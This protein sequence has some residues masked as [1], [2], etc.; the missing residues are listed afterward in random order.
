M[1]NDHERSSDFAGIRFCRAL[2]PLF[3]CL[4]T[5]V[6]CFGAVSAQTAAR[7]LSTAHFAN[8]FTET[9]SV[10]IQIAAGEA[11][12]LVLRDG[13]GT[14]I[15]RREA[16]AEATTL[17]LGQLVP[18]Y[19]EATLG[20][21]MLPLAV[22]IAP[23]KRVVGPGRLATDNAMAW[24]VKPET[25]EDTARLLKLCGFSWVR[26]RL[27][28]NE[29]EAQRG[30]YNWGKYESSISAL[31]RNGINVYDVFHS[32]PPWSRADGDTK[33]APD[34]LRDIYRFAAALQGQF[35]GRVQAYEVWN[36]PDISFFSHPAS[37]CAAFQK[38]AYLGFMHAAKA[39][40]GEKPPLVLS[41]SMAG[42][43]SPFSTHLLENGVANYF[44][45]WN[46][47]IYAD[48]SDY[49]GRTAGFR[50][51][52]AK[53]G[54]T[55]PHWI[56]EAGDRVSGPEGVLTPQSRRHQAEFVSRAFPTAL[57]NGAAR[58]F[59]FVFPFY[60]EGDVGWGLFEPNQK[61][62]FP[63]LAAVS[64]VTYALGHG[65]AL[66]TLATEA[67]THA[68]AFDRGDG[69][70]ALAVWSDDTPRDVAL[71]LDWRQVR[72]ARS[73][74]G[75]PLPLGQGAVKMTATSAATY[76]IVPRAA[77][78]G[79][80][81]P[82][83]AT[84]QG[85][86]RPAIGLPDIVVC[87]RPRNLPVDKDADCYILQTPET[88]L[89][90]EIY[91][92]G[93]TNFNGQIAVS[94]PQNWKIALE[95]SKVNLAAGQ[96]LIVPLKLTTPDAMART[97]I[98][99]VVRSGGKES[100][101]AVLWLAMDPNNAKAIRSLNLKLDD[102]PAWE[103]NIAGNGT[104]TTIAA[105]G[106]GVKFDFV[107][108]TAGDNWA[109]PQH[110][111][112]PPLDLSG[113]N[114]IRFEYRTSVADSGPVRLMIGEPDGA[115]YM[116][117]NGFPGSTTWRTATV[118]LSDLTYLSLSKPDT[119]GQLDTRAVAIIRIGVNSKPQN[120]MLEV[121]NVQAVQL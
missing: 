59:W 121:R 55:A 100:A 64:T 47:H 119:N 105:D 108:H 98:R 12:P 116:T 81:T 51:M 102:A 28:W 13:N 8:V 99:A 26:E 83:T 23:E 36:E 72:E 73:Y 118:S 82:P 70:T 77:L 49:A 33:A 63:G 88:L 112:A 18:N 110:Q 58:H 109:Y 46:Y 10:Q 37:E 93:T 60:R 91:N 5:C 27:S 67:K 75:T 19:Y 14:E 89:D 94:G 29:V 68:L 9:E 2:L 114:A 42:G 84:P 97:S 117:G 40:P 34:D 48:T 16:P 85:L 106:G 115:T 44:D 120:L 104:M 35:K 43:V 78:D 62:P 1:I 30:T 74:L 20:D 69:T 111:F 92:F 15:L 71:P 22:L 32:V 79:K 41:P 66:G 76:F 38:A 45:I 57:A 31:S 65:D 6:L 3:V 11:G 4:F 56:T 80:L 21:A 25:F 7:T 96:R 50:A 17:D 107:F 39:T 24:L 53:Y 101:P 61:S 95:T 54:V 103:K 52:L 90:A 113:Y 86:T 87:L